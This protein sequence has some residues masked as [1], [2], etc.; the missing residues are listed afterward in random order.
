MRKLVS[1]YPNTLMLGI[2]RLAGV[3][4]VTLRDNGHA[5]RSLKY[6]RIQTGKRHIPS[7]AYITH[8]VYV[9][10]IKA[11]CWRYRLY[12]AGVVIRAWP[13]YGARCGA[14]CSL[15]LLKSR[16][17]RPVNL[18]NPVKICLTRSAGVGS[19][20]DNVCICWRLVA[21]LLAMLPNLV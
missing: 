9:L 7:F 3:L 5:G 14:P 19:G 20:E 21:F 8:K 16:A 6:W 15:A 4:H 13:D 2:T 1:K 18:A 10:R 11:A 17:Y 12:P